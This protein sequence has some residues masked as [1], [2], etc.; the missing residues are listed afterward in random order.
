ML[1][2][3]FVESL[4]LRWKSLTPSEKEEIKTQ[5]EVMRK[6]VPIEME[7]HFL[8]KG[9]EGSL[10]WDFVNS[11]YDISK[12][13]AECFSGDP[14][15]AYAVELETLKAVMS[16]AMLAWEHARQHLYKA[17]CDPVVLVNPT[18]VTLLQNSYSQILDAAPYTNADDL[19]WRLKY[20]AIKEKI[21]DRASAAAKS[22]HAKNADARFWVL[23]EWGAIEDKRGKKAKFSRDYAMLVKK[24]FGV[25]I[26]ADT[27]ARDW[28]PKNDKRT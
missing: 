13:F 21:S 17:L 25:L 16:P 19:F 26:G 14:D 27:I 4:L 28:L 24:Q 3:E 8:P 9:I 10:H 2:D 23:Q 20:D 18:T 1:R 6:H 11:S 12:G 7:N 22:Q 5:A 15:F